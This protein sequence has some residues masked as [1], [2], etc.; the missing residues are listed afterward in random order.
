MNKANLTRGAQ[1]FAYNYKIRHHWTGL[2]RLDLTIA[3]T[4]H[5]QKH[6]PCLLLDSEWASWTVFPADEVLLSPGGRPLDDTRSVCWVGSPPHFQN[7]SILIFL[8]RTCQTARPREK[9]IRGGI[10]VFTPNKA[11]THLLSLCF[12]LYVLRVSSWD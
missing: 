9:S 8:L 5:P 1:T 7:K 11:E 3:F 4:E 2:D 10:V 6:E 12:S